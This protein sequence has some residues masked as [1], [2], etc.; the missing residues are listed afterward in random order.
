[1]MHA[2]QQRIENS[3]TEV[4][5]V[6]DA[7]RDPK[8]ATEV[9]HEYT[10]K[11]LL[12]EFVTG[13]ACAGQLLCLESAGL[14]AAGLK[15]LA[16]AA[17]QKTVTL[18]LRSEETCTFVKET[19]REVESATKH[20]TEI[21]GRLGGTTIT[22]KVVTTVTEYFWDV[23]VVFEIFAYIGSDKEGAG[24]VVLRSGERKTQIK[25]TSKDQPYPKRSVKSD[26]EG[27]AT[28]L[29]QHV[30]PDTLQV[31]F[32]VDR[33]HAKCH[34]PRRNKDVDD[35]LESLR[36]IRRWA[37][38]VSEYFR[39]HVWGIEQA[40]G[41]DTGSVSGEGVFV[42]VLPLLE[43]RDHAAEEGA[44]VQVSDLVGVSS[45]A[46]P[47]NATVMLAGDLQALLAGQKQSL[48]EHMQRASTVIGRGK[49]VVG[50]DEA[51]LVT[52][53]QHQ[54]RIVGALE[55]AV[56]FLEHMLRLQ[57]VAA[58]GKE[59][60]SA[61]F[62][63]YMQFHMRKVLREEYTPRA[64]SHAVRRGDHN[65][66][67]VVGIEQVVKGGEMSEPV[68]TV[69]RV[70]GDAESSVMRFAL[71]ASSQVRFGGERHVHSYIAHRFSTESVPQM[72]LVAR[73]RQFSGFVLL[74]G[75]I[76]GAD[77]FLPKHAMI[78]QNKDDLKLP[79][80]LEQIPTPKEFRDAIESLSP[81]Q[82]RFAKAYRSMQLEA[83]LFGVC[84]IQIKPQ[85]EK[86]LNLPADSLTKEIRLT[87]DLLELFIE[88]QI[89]SDLVA[90]QSDT[91]E[92]DDDVSPAA[93]VEK[94]RGHVAAMRKMLDEAKEGE[95]AEQR[96]KAEMA[97]L[98]RKAQQSQEEAA[99][100]R[101]I[102]I[103][104]LAEKRARLQEIRS[105]R[106]LKRDCKAA[107]APS[108]SMSVNTCSAVPKPE[109][110]PQ[111]PQ[112][113]NKPQKQPQ[114]PQQ[115]QQQQ[116][117]QQPHHQDP[118]APCESECYDISSLP[119]VLEQKYEALDEDSCLRPTI[120][121]TAGVWD[122]RF[123]RTLLSK[124][125]HKMVDV[126]E[127]KREK[128]RAFDLLDALTR[129]GVI[130]VDHAALHVVVAATHCF[131]KTLMDTVVQDNV[132]PIEKVERS[133]LIA[134]TA[135]HSAAATQMLRG[136]HASRVQ[137]HS[138]KLFIE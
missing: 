54:A 38:G 105:V 121:K 107:P 18:A 28:W 46:V 34:T 44:V 12:A 20:V 7:T 35:A 73:A 86:V 9:H 29:L 126:D 83:T 125:E 21:S 33:A 1:M 130:E 11:F 134:A 114:Q 27:D 103:S 112:K 45:P 30:L 104:N 75:A 79:L 15:Q 65:P 118:A 93:K 87:Q 63:E 62:T 14:T 8:L 85:L 135:I 123:Q 111:Q 88:Y 4:K 119:Q 53:L 108:R 116:Q 80:M 70:L 95:L 10:D 106:D 5:K 68:T 136:D 66:E 78:V 98:Q 2:V 101:E 6:L 128:D 26:L 42:P 74:V 64:F 16:E 82:Q 48:E 102:T 51:R 57:L 127:Q 122:K 56:D 36:G 138:P 109:S 40:H 76:G 124:E 129:S 115:T 94:V 43:V 47:A 37:T 137:D 55:H 120:I 100:Q 71:N 3:L 81:E 110:R 133:A 113:S 67:G 90:Y 61:D 31:L 24:R 69:S 52:V 25:T 89:P 84:V 117:Q 60:S 91:F 50:P 77:L 92:D 32:R 41:L 96:Q 132:N 97:K 59:V 39:G 19:K 17:R 99:A 72:S 49:G 13:A 131:D 22:D 23:G 58:I